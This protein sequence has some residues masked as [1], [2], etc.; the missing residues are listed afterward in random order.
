MNEVG[1]TYSESS[2]SDTSDESDSGSATFGANKFLA[3]TRSKLSGEYPEEKDELNYADQLSVDVVYNELDETPLSPQSM[4]PHEK[5]SSRAVEGF[6]KGTLPMSE[7][8]TMKHNTNRNVVIPLDPKEP[9]EG[10]RE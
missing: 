10:L 5:W 7:L 3:E 2:D 8:D 6:S 4:N 9:I 1:E